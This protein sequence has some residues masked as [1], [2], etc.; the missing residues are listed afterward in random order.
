M[1]SRRFRAAAAAAA[2]LAAVMPAWAQHHDEA[3][4]HGD[5]ARFHEH[6]WDLWRHGRWLHDRHEG[7]FGWWWVVG[8]AWYFYPEPVYPYPNPYEPPVAVIVNPA[9]GSASPPPPPAPQYW[10]YCSAAGGYYPYVPS[11][12]GGW[13]A[14]PATPS[15]PAAPAPAPK[16]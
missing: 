7:R 16:P 8:G 3:R 6:D 4:F 13:Q 10:Y 12:P 9:A 14:V 11:C 15:A 2:T 1:V 5:I